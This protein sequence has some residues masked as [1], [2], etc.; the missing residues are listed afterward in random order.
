M[1]STTEI[2]DTFNELAR[3]A[4][5]TGCLSEA[6]GWHKRALTLDEQMHPGSPDHAVELNDLVRLL[7]KWG[8]N[9][10][11]YLENVS[12]KHEVMPSKH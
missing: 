9:A 5:A 10:D 1:G 8:S 11:L 4:E 3:L 2:A 12:P 6:E 7:L